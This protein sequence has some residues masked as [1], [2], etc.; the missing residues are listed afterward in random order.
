[1]S[2]IVHPANSEEAKTHASTGMKVV[3]FGAEWCPPCKKIAP[4]LEKLANEQDKW[5]YVAIDVDNCEEYAQENEVGG[6]PEV[7]IIK[8]GQVLKKIVGF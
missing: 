6:I 2:K 4:I 5:T 1:M 3:K 8:D 7:R